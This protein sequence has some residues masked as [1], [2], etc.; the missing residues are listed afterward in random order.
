MSSRRA[1]DGEI[2]A[3]LDAIFH[4]YRHDFRQYA[5]ASMRRRVAHAGR[6]LNLRS[7][8]DLHGY[9]LNGRRQFNEV[10][11]YLTVPVSTMFRDSA[12]FL[13]LR[14][15]VVPRLM[16]HATPRIWVAGCG[17]GEE[18]YSLAI[19]LH[20]KNLLDRT[21]IYATDINPH[22]LESAERAIFSLSNL[23]GYIQNYH[24]SGGRDEFANYYHATCDH[25]VIEKSLRRRIVFS[26]HS[27]AIGAAFTEVNFISCRNTLIYFE[28]ELKDRAIGIFHDSL[29]RNGLL[30]LGAGES[31]EFLTAGAGFGQFDHAA[32]IFQKL[33]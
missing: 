8:G 14:R 23:R 9:M 32:R 33:R 7:L 18:V 6:S 29:C 20:E 11:R 27:L 26:D 10:L 30:G 25:F 19:L 4:Q 31:L 22:A 1:A 16:Q 5:P 17:A 3:F 2:D 12:Y 13:A 15:D 28:R 24:L 21:T